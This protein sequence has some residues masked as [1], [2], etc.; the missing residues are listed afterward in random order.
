MPTVRERV[1]QC[2]RE[3]FSAVNVDES[4]DYR[5]DLD[6]TAADAEEFAEA[7]EAEFGIVI[8]Y[9][10]AVSIINGNVKETL[11]YLDWVHG[12]RDG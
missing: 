7:L 8:P 9:C 4:T 5:T 12:V 3:N 6:A 11:E 10:D 2:V 1:F